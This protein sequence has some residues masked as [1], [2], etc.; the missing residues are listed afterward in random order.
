MIIS[1]TL[2]I[3]K[4]VFASDETCLN[5]KVTYNIRPD[6]VIE[7]YKKEIEFSKNE[8]FTKNINKIAVGGSIDLPLGKIMPI[9]FSFN[10]EKY[11]EFV[12]KSDKQNYK[13]KESR[14]KYPPNMVRIVKEI[15]T[16]IK[17]DGSSSTVRDTELYEVFPIGMTC[18]YDSS[19]LKAIAEEEASNAFLQNCQISI[20]DPDM[21]LNCDCSDPKIC[22]C[23][24]EDKKNCTQLVGNTIIGR[25]SCEKAKTKRKYY[26]IASFECAV[27]RLLPFKA[28]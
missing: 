5:A 11:K 20:N 10:F 21:D 16:S 7:H 8:Q 19:K 22:T 23:N 13:L 27:Y 12:L 18:E 2:T 24:T 14:A 28:Y 3:F 9:G 6:V 15:Q 26:N 17:V 1:A 25:T 4:L